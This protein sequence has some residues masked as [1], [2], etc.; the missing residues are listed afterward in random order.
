MCQMNILNKFKT[1]VIVL[2]LLI[3]GD[4]YVQSQQ[5]VLPFPNITPEEAVEDVLLG[6]GVNAFNISFNGNTNS[7][8]NQQNT[9]RKF[10]YAGAQFPL[11]EGILMHTE[12]GMNITDSDLSAITSNNVTNG[13]IIEFDFIPEGDTLS[14]SYIF[15]SAEYQ[16]YTCSNFNDVFGFFISGPGIS[17]PFTNNAQNIAVIPNSNNIPVGINTVNSGNNPDYG[18]NCA[19]A[20]PNW[21]SDSQ[22]WTNSYNGT[23]NMSGNPLSSYN[24]STVEL[25]ANASVI[26]GETYHIKLAISNVSDQ[27]LNSG[28]FLKAGSFSSEPLVELTGVSTNTSVLSD[29][30]M[31]A[32]CDQGTFCFER[33]SGDISDT[34]IVHYNLLGSA[35]VVVDYGLPNVPNNGDSIIFLPGETEFCLDIVPTDDGAAS[36]IE[37]VIISSYAI[38]ACGDTT[39][40]TAELWIAKE[41]EMPEP[42]AGLDFVVCN[43]DVGTLNG[44]LT[45]QVNHHEWTYS[46]P[47]NV[48]FTPN[49]TDLTAEVAFDTP[50]EYI[51]FLTETNDTCSYSGMDSVIVA[52][53]E[54]SISVSNDTT[55]CQNGEAT[56]SASGLGGSTLTYHWGH[57]PNTGSVQSVLPTQQTDYTVFV[58]TEDGCISETETITVNVLPP[59]DVTSSPWQSVCPGDSAV[60][61]SLASGGNGGPYTYVWTDPNGLVVGTGNTI[62]VIPTETTIYTVTA[63]DNCESTPATST[64]EVNYDPLPEVLFT[65]TDPAICT[66]AVF[67]VINLSDTSLI[68]EMYWKISNGT[69]YANEDTILVE[70]AQ[71]GLYN[72]ELIIVTPNGCIDSSSINNM[73]EVYPLPDPS[74]SYY[75]SPVTIL[76]TNVTFQNATTGAAYYDWTFEGGNPGYSSMKNPTSKFPEGYLDEYDVQL[77]ATSEYNCVD[78]LIKTIEVLPDVQL[79]VPNTFTPDGDGFNE[80]WNVYIQGVDIYNFTLEVYNRWGERVWESHDIEYGWDGTYGGKIVPSGT[81]IWKIRGADF[82]TDEKY[83]WNGH[84]LILR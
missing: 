82:I 39:F 1:F 45:S 55:V 48:I 32:G 16:S 79:Y 25:T 9:V 64:S 20:N 66:P 17:G 15:T 29:T 41:P 35:V 18:G 19:S 54:V 56:L 24:G 36:G 70:I 7:A 34:A 43:G 49:T 31:V 27:A 8:L 73:L 46:G 23:Y 37:N 76:N 74:F 33:A 3:I 30:V 11:T 53:G 57:T 81:Y 6:A 68:D 50:G 47:G 14:F 22:Y 67:E 58:E 61:T 60:L 62:T 5:I 65:V 59:L 63:E 28:V 2:L 13:A 44:S 21:Q 38:N 83:E 42:D 78:T 10:T 77:I 52:Y 51:F 75:P 84:V 69:Q 71:A 4:N 12:T 80:L 72:V 40:T 26:C